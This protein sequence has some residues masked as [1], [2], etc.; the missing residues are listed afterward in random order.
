MLSPAPLLLVR[1]L[2]LCLPLVV[3]FT[4]TTTPNPTGII[5]SSPADEDPVDVYV[6]TTDQLTSGDLKNE[7]FLPPLNKT[8][9][10]TSPAD[11]DPVDIYV[12]TT[13]LTSGDLKNDSFLPPTNKTIAP[14]V[15]LKNASVFP[16]PPPVSY[17]D[18]EDNLLFRAAAG[19]NPEPKN[20]RKVAFMFLTTSSLPLSELWEAFFN[21]TPP[22]LYNIYIHNRQPNARFRGVFANR[23]VSSKI[24][25]RHTP[26]LIS[27]A[28]RLL[29]HALLHDRSNYMFTLLSSA[30]IPLHSFNFTYRTLT[31][32]EKSFI[33]I[34]RNE[35]GAYDRWAA[36]GSDAMLPEVELGKFRIGSQFW[37]LTRRHARAVVNDTRLWSKFRLP[38]VRLDTCYPE[39]HYFSTLLSMQDPRGCVPATLTHVNWRGCY[40]GHPMTYVAPEVGP[41]LI[42][43]LRNDRPRY[44]DDGVNGSDWF[45]SNRSDPFL[46]ARKFTPNS[47]KPLMSIASDVILKD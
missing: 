21:K 44:G 40:D 6:S 26:T 33:E 2:L 20:R 41:E 36:R 42:Q 29:S 13:Q 11:E 14:I 27:A 39:E 4:V 38:C 17:D 5:P 47:L 43:R 18:E 32:S 19:V 46:F 1:A 7:S 3:I 34:L 15:L 16:P 35:P 25:L 8:I 31:R 10:P 24:A 9:A 28:R 22:D 12:S 30:C 37:S 45:N 23:I